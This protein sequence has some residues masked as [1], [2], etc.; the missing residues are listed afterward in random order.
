MPRTQSKLGLTV[1]RLTLNQR[2]FLE[3]SLEMDHFILSALFPDWLSGSH[4]RGPRVGSSPRDTVQARN[5][6]VFTQGGGGVLQPGGWCS[7]AGDQRQ[8]V[9]WAYPQ[10][11]GLEWRTI[12]SCPCSSLRAQVGL[13]LWGIHP[14]NEDR[15]WGHYHG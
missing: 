2:F 8:L 1:D 6:H 4:P 7:H 15:P 9:V 12:S 3:Q 11:W 5:I 13:T 10:S 14:V